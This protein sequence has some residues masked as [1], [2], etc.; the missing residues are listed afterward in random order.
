MEGLELRHRSFRSATVAE[1]PTPR[2]FQLRILM[3]NQIMET[4]YKL[5]DSVG[6]L[7]EWDKFIPFRREFYT[8]I[9]GSSGGP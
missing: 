7:L 4:I 3:A 8:V 5:P 1:A 9:L 6:I 2:Q